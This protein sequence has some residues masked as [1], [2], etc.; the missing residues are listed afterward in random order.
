LTEVLEDRA[1]PAGPGGGGLFGGLFGSIPAQDAAKVAQEFVKFD[2]TY[3]KDV[4]TILFN[5]STPTATTRASFD[6]AVNTALGNLNTAIDKDIANL[7]SASTSLDAT[8]QNELTGS[9]STSLQ[10]EL[11]ALTT[12]TSSGFLSQLMFDIQAARVIVPVTSQV[13]NQVATAPAPAGGID[14][15]TVQKAISTIASAFQSFRMGYNQAVQTDLLGST[16]DRSK[17]DSDVA[18]L[19]TTLNTAVTGAIPSQLPASVGTTITNLLVSNTTNTFNLQ[20]NL[21]SLPTPTAG[22]RFSTFLFNWGSAFYTGAAQAQ[23]V[24]QLIMAVQ[25]YNNSLGSS[26]GT[27]GS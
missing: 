25:T 10:S 4:Q 5:G 11:A 17:F 1:V 21:K 23:V 12:P 26:T 8:I 16:P 27:S 20:D 7:P 22:S 3:F 13:V 18:G 15:A 6:Q 24:H 2:Q 9:A 14:A 19:I